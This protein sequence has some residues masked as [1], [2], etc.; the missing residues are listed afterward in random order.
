MKTIRMIAA[1]VSISLVLSSCSI[2]KNGKD[3]TLSDQAQNEHEAMEHFETLFLNALVESDS[4]TIL[5]AFSEVAKERT[6]DFDES[7]EYIFDI[8]NG[9][10]EP[11]IYDHIVSSYRGFNYSEEGD[12]FWTVKC[13]AKIKAG[14]E[15][16]LLRWTECLEC[17]PDSDGVGVYSVRFDEYDAAFVENPTSSERSDWDM[18]NNFCQFAGIYHPGRKTVN[19][20]MHSISQIQYYGTSQGTL[21]YSEFD[22][23]NADSMGFCF[24]NNLCTPSFDEDRLCVMLF[25]LNKEN[26][27]GTMWIESDGETQVICALSKLDGKDGLLGISID[28]DGKI[29][30]IVFEQNATSLSEIP[31]GI[32]GFEGIEE[33]LDS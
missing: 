5:D 25:L 30:G 9:N 26:S 1:I 23:P 16:Y 14:D 20:I 13:T 11:E 6:D 12:D 3:E 24:S 32:S 17:G 7:L 10:A 4:D 15:Y 21:P 8:Y 18:D 29:S 2:I 22:V 27:I 28:D 31:E 19:D 33:A